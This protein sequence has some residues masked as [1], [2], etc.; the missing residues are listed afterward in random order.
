MDTPG[1]YVCHD[2]EE[3]IASNLLPSMLS[4]IPVIDM[5]LLLAN[6][7]SQLDKLHLACKDWGFFQ[8]MN[9]GVSCLLIEKMKLEVQRFFNLP[10]EEKKKFGQIEG[11]MEGYGQILVSCD[12]QNINSWIGKLYMVTL[13][14]HLRKPQLFP[15]LPLSLRDTLEEYS[16]QL[17]ELSEKIFDIMGKALG[18]KGED[19]SEVF[20][21]GEQAM[22]MYYY[23]KC[24]QEDVVMGLNPHTDLAGL[25]ILSQL[26]DVEGLHIKKDGAWIPITP[27]PNAFVINVG[28]MLEIVT[29]EIYK[30]VEHRPVLNPNKER[31]SIATFFKPKRDYYL[32]PASSLITPR[33]PV[34]FKQIGTVADYFKGYFSHQ[35]VGKSYL[36]TMRLNTKDEE[37][38]T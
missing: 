30:G 24:P 4:Q 29:N 34:K 36:D 38:N 13:P 23:P 3:P 28:D 17:K 6:D 15:N 31:L 16:A 18:M 32:S 9:H 37:I 33:N 20:D 8:M 10:M 11:S 19:L 1:T 12:E 26:N 22:A 27:L 14:I 7:H 21:G 35:L 25:T 2:Q 5:E